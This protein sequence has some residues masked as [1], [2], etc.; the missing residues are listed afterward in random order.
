[1]FRGVS[2]HRRGFTLIELLVVIAII[3]ILIGLLL[4]AVQKVREAAAKM[5]CSNHMKQ[6]A[7]A[8]A[9]FHDAQQVLPPLYGPLGATGNANPVFFWLLPYVEQQA[10]YDTARSGTDFDSRLVGHV[11]V[12]TFTCPSDPSFNGGLAKNIPGT[13]NPNAANGQPWAVG[14]IAANGPAFARYTA[15][16]C[17]GPQY[18]VKVSDQLTLQSGFDGCHQMKLVPG[19]R[20]RLV[21]DY[22]DG[23][24]NTIMFAEKLANCFN[25]LSSYY[26]AASTAWGFRDTNNAERWPAISYDPFVQTAWS[27]MG[28]TKGP[29]PLPS[30]NA[31][32][33][34]DCYGRRSSSAHPSGVNV[35]LADGSTRNVSYAV[36]TTT[37]WHAST[38]A[39][40]AVLGSDW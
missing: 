31:W 37:W 22:T 19:D 13:P 26:Y 30:L 15:S 9:N 11:S 33:G 25:P 2:P 32:N 17:G 27:E 24:S 14:S 6:V 5:T 8:A 10:L 12:K 36:G 20:R 1:M 40:G 34:G 39:N 28:D 16:T 21:S 7:L 29:K 4:P 35:A 38:P 18:G 23:L 3:A